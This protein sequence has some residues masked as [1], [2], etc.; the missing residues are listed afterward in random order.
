MSSS[1]GTL[2]AMLQASRIIDLSLTLAEELPGT[3]PQHMPY[4]HKLWN[5]YAPA[6]SLTGDKIPSRAPY[7]TRFLMID[8]HTATHFD[9]P[10]HFIPPPDSG[11][12]FAGPFGA[13]HGDDVPLAD[14][15]G[16][17]CVIDVRHL[18]S[19]ENGVSPWVTPDH[20]RQW[21]AQHGSLDARDVVL[22]RTG[23]DRY[24]VEGAEGEKYVTRPVLHGSFPG[25]PAPSAECI[26]YLLERGVRCLGIDAPSI[27]AVHQGAPAHQVGLSR[28][29]RYVEGLTRLD[30]LPERGSYFV[31]VPLKI[32]RSTGGPGRA[33]AYVAP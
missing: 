15:Q 9:A 17:A 14:L 1:P 13:Q 12:P 2:A 6:V 18:T 29:I 22:L 20:V 3:W 31:F 30:Q 11:L 25:W 28:G 33:F 7:Q 19:G 27:G 4:Q 10:A 5:W 32:A 16:A 24:Y 21:E 8:E 23:W 26:V